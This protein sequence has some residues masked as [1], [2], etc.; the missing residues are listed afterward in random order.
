MLS[1]GREARV[2]L[3]SMQAGICEKVVFQLG[4]EQWV[5]W[6][7]IGKGDGAVQR[8]CVEWVGVLTK[9][10][11]RTQGDCMDLGGD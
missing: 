7:G 2:G 1:E 3:N 8:W 5:E 11:G 6:V 4:L 9:Q 10:E